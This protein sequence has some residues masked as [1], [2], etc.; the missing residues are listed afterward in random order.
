MKPDLA[1][2]VEAEVRAESLGKDA[3]RYFHLA[4][5]STSC[6]PQS[7]RHLAAATARLAAHWGVIALAARGEG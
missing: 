2:R 6:C 5:Q 4:E 3:V 7:L 1:L